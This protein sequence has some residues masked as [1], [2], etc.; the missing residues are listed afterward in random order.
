M[1]H[2]HYKSVI[3]FT[4]IYSRSPLTLTPK[5][6]EKQFELARVRVTGVAVEF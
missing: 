5:G 3:I 6:N 1:T 2:L 4:I